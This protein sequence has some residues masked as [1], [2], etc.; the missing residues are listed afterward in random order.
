MRRERKRNPVVPRIAAVAVLGIALWLL[1]ANV[2]FVVR[3]VQVVGAGE[4]PEADVRHLSGIRLGTRMSAVNAERVRLDVESDGRVAFVSMER[5]LPNRI[6]LTVRPRTKDAVILQAGKIVVLDSDGFVV[7][8]PD[9]LPDGGAVYVTGLKAAY[10]TLGRQLDTADGRC[11]CM[12]AVLEALKANGATRYV[13]ELSVAVTAD[14]RIITR[15]GMTVLLG[16]SDN[17]NAKIAWMAGA[18]ADLEARGQTTGQLDVSSGTKADYR[19]APRPVEED[20][21]SAETTETA[22]EGEAA[23]LSAESA[24]S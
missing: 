6:V 12:K 22:A 20:E 10:C 4:I 14:L 11:A 15:T 23:E 2:V 13:S 8:M 1:L 7:D 5:R 21:A 3:D 17:M 19:P 24:G 9:R 16:N 18:L